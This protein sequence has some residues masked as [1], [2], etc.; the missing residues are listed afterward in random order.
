MKIRLIVI[1]PTDSAYLKEGISGYISRLK[2]YVTFEY[3][4][5]PAVKRS[6]NFTSAEVKK[7]EGE[8]LLKHVD[9]SSILILLDEK[10]KEYT[11]TDFSKFIQKQMNSGV[12]TIVFF[13]GGPFGF[14]EEVYKK[15]NYKLALSQMTFSHQM[16][17]LFFV[18]QLYR[19][20]TIIKGESYHHE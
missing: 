18:E 10:G 12:K 17:R 13:V 6:G 4:E 8:E 19:A 2:H 11:S 20:F 16:V 1:S 14:P 5:L 7:K 15:A 9:P 3:V